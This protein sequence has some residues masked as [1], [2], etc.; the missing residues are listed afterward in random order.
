MVTRA[1]LD[2]RQTRV[3]SS[4][5][6]V[7]DHPEPI[8]GSPLYLVGTTCLSRPRSYF[9]LH[10]FTEEEWYIPGPISVRHVLTV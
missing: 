4:L 5:F 1:G 6:L 2:G 8:E 10:E 7:S 9:L 3:S